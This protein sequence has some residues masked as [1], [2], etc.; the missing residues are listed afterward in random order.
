LVI[1]TI[2]LLRLALLW[3]EVSGL[4]GRRAP[5]A[6]LWMFDLA[7]AEHIPFALRGDGALP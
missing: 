1:E 2:T 4:F 5:I 7:S 6:W 3:M